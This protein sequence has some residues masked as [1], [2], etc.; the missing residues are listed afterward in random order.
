MT[1]ATQL[2]T[3]RRF[4]FI[5]THLP[6]GLWPDSVT[7]G[8]GAHG[9]PGRRTGGGSVRFCVRLHGLRALGRVCACAAAGGCRESATDRSGCWRSRASLAM[10]P[11]SQGSPALPGASRRA[12]IAFGVRRDCNRVS[13]EERAG[14]PAAPGGRG[15]RHRP[16]SAMD[17]RFVAVGPWVELHPFEPGST[18]PA[19]PHWALTTC[20]SDAGS[21]TAST[22]SAIFSPKPAGALACSD[23][24]ERFQRTPGPGG[25]H[26][27]RTA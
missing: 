5:R 26:G 22:S 17:R 16:W 11:V 1:R 15:P 7:Q 10:S 8:I 20:S 21:L 12:G 13:P 4:L 18:V 27:A 25:W 23:A 3:K 19:D 9:P 14:L 24:I 2:A 6:G